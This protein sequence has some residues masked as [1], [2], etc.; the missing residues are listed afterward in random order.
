M[1]FHFRKSIWQI[2]GRC[3][4]KIKMLALNEF[5]TGKTV[6]PKNREKCIF[7][8]AFPSA[9]HVFRYLLKVRSTI[10]DIKYSV[11]VN[12]HDVSFTLQNEYLHK[13]NTSARNNA[14][15]PPRPLPRRPLAKDDSRARLA[16]CNRSPI[17]KTKKKL[18]TAQ[19]L[20]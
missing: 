14:H 18:V 10:Y 15:L 20:F 13:E 4:K 19:T 16:R 17:C 9:A 7:C 2:W 8:P 6:T 3:K 11:A 12:F 1:S 5:W